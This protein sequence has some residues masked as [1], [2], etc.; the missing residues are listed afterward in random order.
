MAENTDL[1]QRGGAWAN[2]VNSAVLGI[3]RAP[4]ECVEMRERVWEET[5]IH[6]DINSLRQTKKS[7]GVAVEAEEYR[8]LDTKIENHFKEEGA[9]CASFFK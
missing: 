6:L 2:G 1:N 4:R 8:A 5:S 3:E 9:H 7:E